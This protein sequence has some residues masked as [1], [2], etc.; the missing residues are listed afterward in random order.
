MAENAGNSANRGEKGK[1]DG[2]KLRILLRTFGCQM[3]ALQQDYGEAENLLKFK[4]NQK[5]HLTNKGWSSILVMAIVFN[6]E[7]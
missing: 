3:V 5:K 1:K 6:K 7:L 2:K 4:K